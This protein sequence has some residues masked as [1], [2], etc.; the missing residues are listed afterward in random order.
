MRFQNVSYNILNTF[1]KKSLSVGM[2]LWATVFDRYRIIC[3]TELVLKFSTLPIIKIY[4][5]ML[6]YQ[7]NIDVV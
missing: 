4:P 7:Y 2:L 5:S 1:K 3:H 6:N